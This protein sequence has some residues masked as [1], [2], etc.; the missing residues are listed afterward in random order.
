M[1]QVSK[2]SAS[3]SEHVFTIATPN[4]FPQASV[5]AASLIASDD[6]ADFSLV[7][8]C[9]QDVSHFVVDFLVGVTEIIESWG[10]EVPS[11]VRSRIHLR[12]LSEF[13]WPSFPLV[14]ATVY[15]NILEFA[16]AIKPFLTVSLMNDLQI[17]QLTYLDPDIMLFDSLEWLTR[18]FELGSML[19][20]PHLLNV[21][22]PELF[23]HDLMILR[24]GV[25]NLGFAGVRREAL[26]FIEWWG[27]KCAFG[28]FMDVDAGMHNDQRWVDM[29]PALQMNT[30]IVRDPGVNL[31]YWN[32]PERRLDSQNQV[33]MQGVSSPLKFFH[34]SGFDRRLPSM[35]SRHLPRPLELSRESKATLDL[36]M[37][38]YA[39]ALSIAERRT[40][41]PRAWSFAGSRAPLTAMPMF[42]RKALCDQVREATTC[43][44]SDIDGDLGVRSL[45]FLK[46]WADQEMTRRP[47]PGP[48]AL[49]RQE[50]PDLR[51]LPEAD[52]RVWVRQAGAYELPLDPGHARLISMA[53]RTHEVSRRSRVL[54]AGYF[55]APTGMGRL[56]RALLQWVASQLQGVEVTVLCLPTEGDRDDLVAQALEVGTTCDFGEIFPLAFICVNADSWTQWRHIR[57]ERS[58]Q[59]SYTVGIWA[60]E[61]EWLPQEAREASHHVDEVW[62]IGAVFADAMAATLTCKVAHLRPYGLPSRWAGTDAGHKVDPPLEVSEAQVSERRQVLGVFDLKSVEA[63]KNVSGLLAIWPCVAALHPAAH[64]KIKLGTGAGHES[65]LMALQA[66]A[67]TMERIELIVGDLSDQ[68]VEEMY[69][70]SWALV[71]LHRSEG[72]GFPMAEAQALGLPVIYTN[73]GG[74]TDFLDA[75]LHFPVEW[76][77]TIV[78]TYGAPYPPH[79]L[80]AEPN[81]EHAVEQ[82]SKVL[83]LSLDSMNSLRRAI[84]ASHEAQLESA[85]LCNGSVLNQTLV[86]ATF[87]PAPIPPGGV[88][89]IS[90]KYQHALARARR[91][92]LTSYRKWPSGSRRARLAR[93]VSNSRALR[94]VLGV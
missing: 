90:L 41:N 35:I 19:L 49:L 11:D 45:E 5:L 28:S 66:L 20:T 27:R 21:R 38:D 79:A 77:W 54:V 39:R 55:G 94:R 48:I 8:I 84:A 30:R 15:Y 93:R 50:R 4:Y 42:M 16:T 68:E 53:G 17:D 65:E 62:T 18:E 44:P 75:G 23:S 10:H 14:E 25:F 64:L 32:L 51:G 36:L 59:L 83:S 63:R 89:A 81:L 78:G 60:W 12:S 47:A 57:E 2:R 9:D 6:S 71:S 61:L 37:T 87:R 88:D 91:R 58:L 70:Q 26:D 73:Y 69:R 24:A 43:A 67:A 80:W 40:P 56:G 72:F 29:A 86:D 22:S 46:H 34:F 1:R 33:W 52:L 74:P 13:D 85:A 82:L 7:V 76:D 31:A 92:A 3:P